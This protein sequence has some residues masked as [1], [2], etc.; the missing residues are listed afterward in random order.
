MLVLQ[1]WLLGH[2]KR[3]VEVHRETEVG[4]LVA[5]ALVL[6]VPV[7]KVNLRVQ[8][9]TSPRVQNPEARIASNN[10]AME[11]IPVVAKVASTLATSTVP[12]PLQMDQT[13]TK[14][15]KMEMPIG[16]EHARRQGEKK[17]SGRK[18]KNSNGKEMQR[19]ARS[20]NSVNTKQWTENSESAKRNLKRKWL[21]LEKRPRGKHD[22]ALKEKLQRPDPKLNEKQLKPEPGPKKKLRK[23]QLKQRKKLRK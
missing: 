9:Q 17:G 19:H 3:A 18:W 11:E 6:E 12:V 20:K 2:R 7:L 13:V 14:R 1:D 10:T 16:I 8:V 15:K 21:Q 4:D 22:N 23:Q 5:G